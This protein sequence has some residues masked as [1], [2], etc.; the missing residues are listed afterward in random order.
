MTF[1]R[2]TYSAAALIAG[3]IVGGPAQAHPKLVST[4]PQAQ[5]QGP[6]P[7]QIELHFSESLVR[8]FSGAK[9]VMTAMPGMGA[10][11]PM[12][13]E[14]RISGSDDPKVMVITP[15]RPLAPGTYRV[16]WRAVSSDTHPVTGNFSFQVK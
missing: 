12:A 5:A 8:Q 14:S 13:I 16:E 15:A 6:A 10:H 7:K 11:A 3:L 1:V 9:L 2:T 4:V